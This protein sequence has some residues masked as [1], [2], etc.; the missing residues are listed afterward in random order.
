MRIYC[1][2][3]TEDILKSEATSLVLRL[4][5][6]LE[7]QEVSTAG[8]P[9]AI[10]LGHQ[11]EPYFPSEIYM[12]H[13]FYWFGVRATL[14]GRLIG[15]VVKNIKT[16]AK[17]C[18]ALDYTPTHAYRKT[19]VGNDEQRKQWRE[20]I[21]GELNLHKDAVRA[22]ESLE[23]IKRFI[24]H[25][26]RFRKPDLTQLQAMDVPIN[27][28]VI[29]FGSP[30]SGKSMLALE[31]AK[32][33]VEAG[34]AVSIVVPTQLLATKLYAELADSCH[35]SKINCWSWE[36]YLSKIAQYYPEL[37]LI[38]EK[39]DGRR[40]VD[41]FLFAE[42][43]HELDKKIKALAPYSVLWQEFQYVL[44][45][46]NWEN[47]SSLFLSLNE[48]QGLGIAQSSISQE[49]RK[50]LYNTVF[51]PFFR[52]VSD[53]LKFYCPI[54]KAHELYSQLKINRAPLI[55]DALILDEVQ[56]FHPWAWAC[57]LALLKHPLSCGQFFISGD[58]HQSVECQ[59]LRVLE[60]LRDYLA[61]EQALFPIISLEENHRSTKKVWGLVNRI[62]NAEL[63]LLGSLE[64]DTHVIMKVSE[65]AEEGSVTQG[66]YSPEY[67]TRIAEDSHAYVVI[68]DESSRAEAENLWPT[69]QIVTRSEFQGVSA[70]TIV[71][72]GF[73]RWYK[74]VLNE[75]EMALKSV[76]DSDLDSLQPYARKSKGEENALNK[77]VIFQALYTSAS[78]A[79]KELFILES[80]DNKVHP[81]F[82]R[83][84]PKVIQEIAAEPLEMPKSKSS[85][86]EEW[87]AR[88]EQD[89][90]NGLRTQALQIFSQ[91][92]LW[93]KEKVE[94]VHKF[95]SQHTQTH[96]H[97]L[98]GT[99]NEAD[100]KKFFAAIREILFPSQSKQLVVPKKVS[101]P[102]KPAQD[103]IPP[104]PVSTPVLSKW[105]LFVED[106]FKLC[107]NTKNVEAFLNLKKEK[108]VELLFVHLMMNDYCLF[109][110]MVLLGKSDVFF[111]GLKKN[112]GL[113]D[114]LKKKCIEF[115]KTNPL[116]RL[117]LQIMIDSF[118][119]HPRFIFSIKTFMLLIN[120]NGALFL[121]LHWKPGGKDLLPPEMMCQS[122]A[123]DELTAFFLLLEVEGGQDLVIQNWEYFKKKGLLSPISMHQ[124]VTEDGEYQ[125]KTAF[126]LLIENPEGEQL[127]INRWQD[128]KE[129]GLLSPSS[130]HQLVTVE[131]QIDGVTAFY[132]LSAT[133]EGR[134][135][136]IERWQD[137]K[138]LGL[139]SPISMH[140]AVTEVGEIHGMTSFHCLVETSEGQKLIIDHWQDFKELGLLSPVSM[141][142]AVTEAGKRQGITPFHC[143]AE[144]SEGQKLINDKW[145]DFK[146]LGLLS[147]SS[148][149]Q[150][151]TIE[152]EIDGVTAFYILTASLEGRQ[153]LIDRWQ[154]FKELGLLSPA[155]MHQVVM[156]VGEHQGMTPFYS[157]VE[158]PEGQ[159]L[160]NDQWQDFKKLGLLSPVSMHQV[161]MEVGEH[162]G[163]T[164]FYFL[165]ATPQGRQLII[166]R[167]QDFKELGLLS[168]A[169]MHQVV[170]AVG[171]HQG[172]TPF[173][174]LTGTFKGQELIIRQW[175][176]F[177]E[178]GLLSPRSMNQVVQEAPGKANTAFIL[179][180]LTSQSKK[181]L[182]D[183]WQFLKKEGLLPSKIE[184][185]FVD[186]LKAQPLWAELEPLFQ[187]EGY[188]EVPVLSSS[189]SG[190]SFF[191][192]A[193]QKE[194]EQQ[195]VHLASL[196]DSF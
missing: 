83:M 116:L 178:L 46:P 140:Q 143:L 78:R 95:L 19:M 64:R 113:M 145:Q 1:T 149:H 177:K 23:P 14:P 190:Q 196:G 18:F 75:I 33:Y 27:Q 165:T 146:E 168:P 128:F 35:Q 180:L 147:P 70:E 122:L 120:M 11:V 108:I 137:F 119:K 26:G 161:V 114:Y 121:G 96:Q 127:L 62:H 135:L 85:T 28:G 73:S 43:Y 123:G 107:T 164:A 179:L 109:I 49:N 98:E 31:R 79:E 151:V 87:F 144:T 186:Q 12:G 25:K 152:G 172:M 45:R 71:M 56:T 175:Q 133:F 181:L 72:F 159:K 39:G 100:M 41:V 139:L 82:S 68:P 42:H 106:F 69:H 117:C 30:G 16:G 155:S 5:S 86:P 163:M 37:N 36:E 63:I 105:A 129:L 51:Y 91:E 101:V 90:I 65:T 171:D 15:C 58:A 94:T 134:L 132:I 24:S 174:F 166:E 115:E 55:F 8:L 22:Q 167:W 29:C 162:Q 111:Q 160:I 81:F 110:N 40:L 61:Q 102:A 191:P 188:I 138:E 184:R 52:K 53:S 88:A 76:P 77:R 66:I 89:Y 183:E 154:D 153:L 170:T 173:Y 141:H 60:P 93:G 48:Y 80:S 157:L 150:V 185:E 84:L 142:Q 169:S 10:P 17:T 2:K 32:S 92:A 67:R 124:V 38:H 4:N 34:L 57:L 182:I 3:K 104:K 20:F 118:E 136:I 74:E 6:F 13:K 130:M 7:K 193:A 187:K 59:Q 99:L 103:L 158:T 194:S 21:I 156:E 54:R 176:D 126:Y 50:V 148:M 47:P 192:G 189:L 125:G 131:G 195:S 9:A 44:M 97:C 112:P